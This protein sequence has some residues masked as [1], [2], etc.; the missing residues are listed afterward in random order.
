MDYLGHPMM[1]ASTL[2]L[3]G[4]VY[5]AAHEVEQYPVPMLGRLGDAFAIRRLLQWWTY[6]TLATPWVLIK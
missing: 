4:N 1:P 3:A 2:R 5:E 6:W